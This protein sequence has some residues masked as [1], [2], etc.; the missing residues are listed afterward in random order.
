MTLDLA[1]LT[2]GWDCPSGELRARVVVGRDG[3]E[4]LQLRVDLG[5][6]QMFPD[7]RPD[8]E[9]VH[10]LPSA[11]EFIQRELRVHSQHLTECDWRELE[12]ELLQMNYRRMALGALAEDA[13]HGNDGDAAQRFLQQALNDTTMCMENLALLTEHAGTID[14]HASLRPTLAF[15]QARLAAQ[16][17]IV[18]GRFEDAVEQA[19]S[20]AAALEDVLAEMGC[21]GEQ[22]DE[23]PGLC[24]LRNLGVHLRRE[25]GIAQT[26]SEQLAEAVENEDFET[27]ARLRDELARRRCDSHAAPDSPA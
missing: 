22:R 23:D 20:G 11:R 27:A 16:L 5:I 4:L 14:G 24:Y 2:A 9:R 17:C 3:G 25:Y 18:E 6:M 15:D 21:E 10:G 12:R 19:E 1:E 26:L 8:G 13:L 7:G